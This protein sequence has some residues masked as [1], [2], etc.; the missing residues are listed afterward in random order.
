MKR[1]RDWFRIRMNIL[2]IILTTVG[3]VIM[4]KVGRRHMEA[5]QNLSNDNRE[6]HRKN[7]EEH[8]AK[9]AAKE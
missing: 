5:G 9:M 8:K 7:R 1:G 4:I 2:M 6:W 3:S